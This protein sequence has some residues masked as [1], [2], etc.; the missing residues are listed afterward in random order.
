M[1]QLDGITNE[2]EL[3]QTPRD[4]EGQGGLMRC[5]PWGHEESDVTGQLNNNSMP[6]LF[7]FFFLILY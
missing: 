4:G 1:R 3:G 6:F 2:H 7:Y 5:S